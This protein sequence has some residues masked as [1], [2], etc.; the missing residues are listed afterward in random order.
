MQAAFLLPDGVVL[1]LN[2]HERGQKVTAAS[3]SGQA[4]QSL[5]EQRNAERRDGHRGVGG[6][7]QIYTT[8]S[9]P[10]RG[11]HGSWTRVSRP[12]SIR[13]VEACCRVEVP[14]ATLS[15]QLLSLCQVFYACGTDHAKSNGLYKGLLPERL[16][17]VVLV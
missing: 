4:L 12:A 15:H 11:R 7:Q 3:V 17:Y 16:G 13:R 6:G 9:R 8:L 5:L 2:G 1:P 10:T 14:Q